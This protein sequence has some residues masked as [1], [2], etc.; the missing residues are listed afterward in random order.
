MNILA[1]ESSCDEFSVAI[2]KDGKVLS[3]IISSQIEQH[4]E[5]GGVV[6]ELASRLHVQ[7][8]HWVLDEAIIEAGIKLEE[9]NYIVYTSNPGLIGSL[10]IGKIVAQTLAQYLKI[11]LLP[12]NHLHGHVYSAFI[13]NDIEFPAVALITSGGHTEIILMKDHLEF[14]TLGQTQDD[15]IGECFD[16]VA[17]KM[18]LT[19]PGG[20]AIDKIAKISNE[21]KY[22]IPKPR[23]INEYDF[24]FSGIKTG[25]INLLHKLKQSKTEL[26][27]NSFAYSFQKTCVEYVIEKLEKAVKKYEPKFVILGG[28]VSANSMLRNKFQEMAKENKIKSIIPKHEY[29]T[30]NAAMMGMLGYRTIIKLRK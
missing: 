30:D 24:S 11:P 29:C 23:D 6:P 16:K 19:Y 10:I 3:N 28:G 1:I 4:K 21:S 14:E 9:L 17:I 26:D 5:Y 25:S 7:N 18:G 12:L 13:E 8:F 20:P 22:K 15:A 27:L 2:L